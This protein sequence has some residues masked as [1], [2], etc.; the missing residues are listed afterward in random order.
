MATG[1]ATWAYRDRHHESFGRTFFRRWGDGLVSS[2]GLGTYLGEPTDAVDSQYEA[3]IAT[4]LE[5]GCNVIDTAINYRCQRS[6]RTVGR[7]LADSEVSRDAVFVATKGGFL[8]FDGEQ[9]TNPGQYIR[10]TYVDTG[11]IDP[12]T[13]VAGSHCLAPAF[14]DDQLERSLEN[15]ELETIDCYYLHNPETQL[16]ENSREAV[17]DQLEAA[18]CQLERRAAAGDI[19]Q[20]GVATWDAFRVQPDHPSYLSLPAVIERARAAAR[21]VGTGGTH[22]G[23]IQLPFNI[24]MADAF[25]VKAHNTPEGPK[26]AL[27][28]AAD[29]GINVFIS[30]SIG[31]G[32]L[33]A[34]GSIPGEVAAKLEGETPVGRAI[35]FARSA[36]GVTA[37]LVGMSRPEHVEEN[38]AACTFDPLGAMAFDAVFE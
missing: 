5:G 22:F 13:L 33:A 29:A 36:P 12:D 20:Y 16:R 10:E 4:A 1:P 2:L 3:A 38:L 21:E 7:A 32:A 15:L 19:R 24:G 28:F 37:S 18:F 30:A 23:A 25:T 17:Y 6:E 35:N 31:Q 14:I 26:S 8:P 34:D 9:P 27:W 11:L